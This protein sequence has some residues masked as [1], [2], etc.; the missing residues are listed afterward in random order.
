[1]QV[2]FPVE[3]HFDEDCGLTCCT[4]GRPLKH[5]VTLSDG[6]L[7]G[8]DCAAVAMGRPRGKRTYDAIEREARVAAAKAAG[9]KYFAENPKPREWA[10]RQEWGVKARMACP[11]AD[12][13]LE[14]HAFF[15]N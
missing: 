15:D 1:M 6:I 11:Y 5:A 7:R 12:Y 10:A 3:Y 13:T 8:L 2:L 9:A 14:C 4:C